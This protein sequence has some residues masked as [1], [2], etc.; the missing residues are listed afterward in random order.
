M[1]YE[2]LYNN[3]KELFPDE[4]EILT[5]YEMESGA[6]PSDG[7]HILFSFVVIPFILSLLQADNPSALR[8]AF[9]YFEEMASSDST[10][11]V[12]VLEFT[13]IEN[14]LSHGKEIAD[15]AK[16]YMGQETLKSCQVI[17]PYFSSDRAARD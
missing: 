3:F 5:K 12:E 11:V 15:K 10:Q 13:V 1:T 17:E 6:S 16:K 8:R 9:A 2:K 4:K 14:L 7:P